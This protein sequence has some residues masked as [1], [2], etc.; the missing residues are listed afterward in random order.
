MKISVVIPCYNV[1]S[2]IEECV[3]SVLKQEYRDLEIICVDNRSTDN[4]WAVLEKMSEKS[5]MIRLSKENKQ[6]A[7]VAR[8][9]G[10]N[11]SEGEYIQFLDADDLLKPQKLSEQVRMIQSLAVKPDVLLEGY[12]QFDETSGK[13]FHKKIDHKNA[14]VALAQS[15]V[16]ITSSNLYRTDILK[17]VG[18]WHPDILSSQDTWLLFKLLKNGVE[19]SYS[20]ELNT[21]RRYRSGSI[22][23][24]NKLENWLRYLEL[25]I[26]LMDYLKEHNPEIFK[27]YENEF[28]QSLFYPIRSIYTYSPQTSLELYNRHFKGAT[29]KREGSVSGTYKLVHDLFGFRVAQKLK[30]II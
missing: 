3:D 28:I 11:L 21:I 29:L 1:E 2:Y 26:E 20:Q 19:I 18:G 6:G 9:N 23:K 7:P 8:N 16:G 12:I 13:K 4:T 22:S 14:W 30:S 25:R 5:P 10:L 15:K 17:K 24:T 27:T